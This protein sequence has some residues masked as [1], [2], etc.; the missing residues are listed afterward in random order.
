MKKL[1]AMLIILTIFPFKF[2]S[3]SINSDEGDEWLTNARIL[4]PYSYNL[5]WE[6]AIK[7]AVENNANVILDWAGFSDTYQGRILNINESIEELKEKTNFIHSN[8]PGIKYVVYVAPLEMQ[9]IDSDMNEDG[10]DD[11]GKNSAYTD[12][13]EWLQVGK[14][15][16]KAVFY[17][18]LP[19]MPFWVDEKSEDVWLSPSNREYKNIVLNI[20]KEIANFV[21]GV[22]LDV[23][24]LCFEFGDVWKEQWCSLDEA[25]M[26]D[27]YNDTGFILSPPLSPDWNNSSWLAFVKWRYKQINDFVGD[28]NKALKEVNPNCKLIVETSSSTVSSTQHGVDL[29]LLNGACDAICHEYGGPFED[30]QYYGWI[31]MLAHLKLWH[32]I[33]KNYSFLLSYVDGN[34]LNLLKFHAGI[35]LASCYDNYYA[36]GDETMSGYI[37]ENFLKELFRWLSN[38]DDYFCGWKNNPEIALIFSRNTLDY[39][40]K[41]S[42][43]G[44]A[45]HDEITGSIMMLIQSNIQFK[46]ID[47]RNLEE[48]KKYKAVI[49]PEFSCMSEEQ[50]NILREYVMNGGILISTHETSLYNEYGIRRENFLLNDLFGVNLSDIEEKIYLNEYGKGKSIFYPLPVGRYYIWEANPWEEEGNEI[51]AEKWR[52]KFLELIE[53]AN[54][55]QDFEISGNAVAFKYEKDGR[56]EIRIINFGG[57]EE[58]RIK[59]KIKDVKILNF[60]EEIIDVEF[61]ENGNETIVYGNFSNQCTILYSKDE[62]LFVEILKPSKG[63]I[64]FMDREIAIINSEKAII[65]GKIYVEVTT[66]GNK[67]EFYLND[68]IEFIDYSPPFEWLLSKNCFGNYEIKAISYLNGRSKEDSLSAFILQISF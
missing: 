33:D 31:Y 5:S 9:T 43:E 11:D 8:F 46:V 29:E 35:I 10:K 26:K 34:N 7:K 53:K 37:N 1:V 48:I 19:G 52:G 39:A 27:F 44:Y 51:E 65:I 47:E 60:M 25:S 16:R 28:F 22:W 67:V 15:A 3:H 2:K 64:Y 32:D 66:N 61:Y 4:T 36:S 38:N 57:L 30:L 59:G 21:D 17:G 56:E 40:D 18:C 6:D 20:A 14:D 68:K 45:Y 12:H 54:A 50:A 55:P 41:G 58:I 63:K 62:E 13:P 24:H 42:W 49:L 23:P